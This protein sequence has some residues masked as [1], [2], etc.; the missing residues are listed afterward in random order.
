MK[1]N[2]CEHQVAHCQM[3]TGHGDDVKCRFVCD[4]CNEEFESEDRCISQIVFKMDISQPASARE[5]KPSVAVSKEASQIVGEIIMEY[6][7][8]E[9]T[10]R[11]TLKQVPGHD[12][13]SFM[14]EDLKRLTK[15]LPQILEQSAGEEWKTFFKKCVKELRSAFD[16]VQPKRNTLVHGQLEV[17]VSETIFINASEEDTPT[18]PGESWYTMKHPQ[19]GTVSLTESE[20]SKVSA[21]AIELRNQVG[22]L[23]Q[24]AGFQRTLSSGDTP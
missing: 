10:L 7:L 5:F 15:W 22:F 8:A 4:N 3:P 16:A 11:E 2:D 17:H 14:S 19:H 21:E 24:L 1:R 13:R 9:H 12:D 20:L 6:A 23:Q 18:E